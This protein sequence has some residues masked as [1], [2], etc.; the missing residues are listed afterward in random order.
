MEMQKWTQSTTQKDIL[1]SG[2][3]FLALEASIRHVN[4]KFWSLTPRVDL[5]ATRG[6]LFL[7][8]P[9]NFPGAFYFAANNERLES[10]M[11]FYFMCRMKA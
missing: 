6:F 10:G 7:K 4:A 9:G 5:V 11:L 2:A 8:S 1:I 3:S